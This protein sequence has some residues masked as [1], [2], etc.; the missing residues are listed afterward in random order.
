[1]HRAHSLRNEEA[2]QHPGLEEGAVLEEDGRFSLGEN[3]DQSHHHAK[4]MQR[5]LGGLFPI[6][7]G[8]DRSGP[9]QQRKRKNEERAPFFRVVAVIVAT[10]SLAV[11]DRQTPPVISYAMVVE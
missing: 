6:Q 11:G 1:M 10:V 5:R 3:D 4:A 2:L 9:K 8:I 7:R